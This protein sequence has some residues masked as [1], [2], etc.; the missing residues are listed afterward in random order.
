L[1]RGTTSI[2][3]DSHLAALE[4]AREESTLILRNFYKGRASW[5][6]HGV[7]LELSAELERQRISV[8]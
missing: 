4:G 2:L 3:Q 5:I 6:R 8:F 7:R 1:F